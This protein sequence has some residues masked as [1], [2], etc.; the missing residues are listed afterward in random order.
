MEKL[1]KSK[2]YVKRNKSAG[3]RRKDLFNRGLG[4]EKD[5]CEACLL[6][7]CPCFRIKTDPNMRNGQ[8]TNNANNMQHIVCVFIDEN[9]H[10][11]NL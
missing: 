3:P 5:D 1:I 6:G 10:I 9:E 8:K 2:Y 4:H 11:Y 7:R